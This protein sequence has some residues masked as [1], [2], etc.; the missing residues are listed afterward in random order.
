MRLDLIPSNYLQIYIIAIS[1]YI[2][3]VLILYNPSSV[4]IG[5]AG[6]KNWEFQPVIPQN[7]TLQGRKYGPRWLKGTGTTSLTSTG[8]PLAALNKL[9]LEG[10]NE[11]LQWR[12][13]WGATGGL[14]PHPKF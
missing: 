6:A 1:I 2:I 10:L 4:Q 7:L 5:A 13:E 12:S 9:P 8:M 11:W 14:Q 3:N